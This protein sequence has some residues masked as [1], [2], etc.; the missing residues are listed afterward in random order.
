MLDNQLKN[1]SEKKK[2]K[3]TTKKTTNK[4]QKTST[5]R[6]YIENKNTN[7][8]KSSVQNLHQDFGPYSNILISDVKRYGVGGPAVISPWSTG[9]LPPLLINIHIKDKLTH[10]HKQTN[11]KLKHTCKYS[12]KQSQHSQMQNCF[13]Y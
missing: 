9:K 13:L 4:I 2:K 11:N 12:T 5:A 8:S 10:T 3:T 1:F 6:V 7:S